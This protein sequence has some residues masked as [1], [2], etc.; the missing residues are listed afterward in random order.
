VLV[1]F[2]LDPACA[3]ADAR[4]RPTR[5]TKNVHSCAREKLIKA[6]SRVLFP[7]IVCRRPHASCVTRAMLLPIKNL[8]SI[9][10]V[11]NR[12][13]N[14]NSTHKG[15]RMTRKLKTLG[16]ALVAVL[17]LTAVMASAAS[18]AKYTASSYPTTGT[19][20]SAIGNDTFI[21]EG[22]TVECQSHFE[23]T[24]AAASE[25]LTVTAKY[26]NCRAFGFLEAVVSHCKYTFTAPSGS[27][28]NYTAIVHVVNAPCTIT[29]GTCKVSIPLQNSLSSVAI[30]NNTASKDVSVKAGVKGIKYNVTQDG[31]L[32]PFASAGE[33][34]GA[35]YIQ[36]NAVTFDS[37][38]GADIDVG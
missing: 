37:T 38:N 29:A 15:V 21:T 2:A 12:A 31:F 19:G 24:L 10:V 7:A 23:G 36:H 30:T 14:Q 3:S 1:G 6:I 33:K 9:T 34:T 32:C 22:G 18:A 13:H 11:L 8:I 16:V 5:E 35:E 20:E 4:D 27:G 26:T 17:A 25:D 28:D